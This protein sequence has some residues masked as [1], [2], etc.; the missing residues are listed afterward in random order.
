MSPIRNYQAWRNYYPSQVWGDYIAA[1]A[2]DILD[3]SDIDR[4]NAY[5][6]LLCWAWTDTLTDTIDFPQ[7]KH[8]YPNHMPYGTIGQGAAGEMCDISKIPA[9]KRYVV[10]NEKVRIDI[11]QSGGTGATYVW[12]AFYQ[13][14]KSAT[15]VPHPI[16]DSHPDVLMCVHSA[17]AITDGLANSDIE[18]CGKAGEILA[19]ASSQN[20]TAAGTCHV[21]AAQRG[22]RVNNQFQVPDASA[23]VGQVDIS[24]M[25]PMRIKKDEQTTPIITLSDGG[26]VQTLVAGL[27]TYAPIYY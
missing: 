4:V 18:R 25:P 12:C 3:G 27:Y 2:T 9:Y 24:S 14:Q 6:W 1:D 15:P 26:T 13:T 21:E 22:H 16:A 11:T 7:Y 8:E 5:G 20:D 10:P 17:N 19:W 23:A